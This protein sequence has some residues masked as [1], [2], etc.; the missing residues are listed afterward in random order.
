MDAIPEGGAFPLTDYPEKLLSLWGVEA[1]AS[2]PE[3]TLPTPHRKF[4]FLP[5][6]VPLTN[7]S[8]AQTGEGTLT[9]RSDSVS[10]EDAVSSLSDS[11]PASSLGYL[12]VTRAPTRVH[13][14][15]DSVPRVVTGVCCCVTQG[16]SQTRAG[17][18]V[19]LEPS[20]IGA[21][22]PWDTVVLKVRHCAFCPGGQS[23][24]QQPCSS[25]VRRICWCSRSFPLGFK[26]KS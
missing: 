26:G 22:R 9:S 25:L 3:P 1:L 18:P 12:F 20:V 10:P 5:V 17:F 23:L 7:D 24:P 19:F 16:P 14:Q 21:R 13:T 11:R 2:E 6:G 4:L 15:Q 8:G